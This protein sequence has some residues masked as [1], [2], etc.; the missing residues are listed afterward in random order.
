MGRYA[1]VICGPAGAGKST[2][3]R[4]VQLHCEATKRVTHVVNLDPAA[5]KVEYQVSMDIRELITVDDVMEELGYGPNGAL[6]Y[7]MEYLIQNSEWL[8][9]QLGGF[10]DDYL[11]FDMPGQIELYSHLG[12]VPRLCATLQRLGYNMCAV[13]LLDSHFLSDAGKFLS[14]TAQALSAMIHLELPHV[15]IISK[16]DLLPNAQEH[17]EIY[18]KYFDTDVPTLL[19]EMQSNTPKRFHRMNEALANVI[20]EYSMVSFLPFDPHDEESISLVLQHIDHSIQFGEDEEPLE[21]KERNTD[22]GYL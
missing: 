11:I 13:Y 3:C 4:T 22:E 8:E 12:V 17:P 16:M 2:F 18:E 10:E 1:Q 6:V 9:E 19:N 15:N 14:G 20:D 7:C 5:D 21:P